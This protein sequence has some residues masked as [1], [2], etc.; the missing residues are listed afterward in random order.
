[1]R[2][3]GTAVARMR[4]PAR[5][6]FAARIAVAIEG[7]SYT[8]TRRCRNARARNKH[9]GDAKAP[10]AGNGKGNAAHLR[11]AIDQPLREQRYRTAGRVTLAT[12]HPRRARDVEVGPAR[13]LGE[14]RQ[15]QRCGHR[16][17]ALA[18]DVG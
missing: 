1:M 4:V 11:A 17:G 3:R 6:A 16:A 7:R 14:S 10:V 8:T 12:G 18:A 13:A 15:E 9:D 5:K 2:P